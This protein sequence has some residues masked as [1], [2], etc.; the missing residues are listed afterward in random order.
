[1]NLYLYEEIM[2]L[3]LRDDKGTVA[4][5][6]V[7]QAVAGAVFAELLLMKKITI[8]EDKKKHVKV[9]NGANCGDPI[10]D[11][12]FAILKNKTKDISVQDLLPKFADIKELKH[13]VARQLCDRGILKAEQDKVLFI[14]TRKTYPELNPVP[15]Q[16]IIK[17][18]SV[19]IFEQP[20]EIDPRTLVLISLAQGTGLLEQNFDRK[21]LKEKKERIEQIV[22]GELAGN[23]T[24]EVIAAYEAAVFIAAIL[25]T[26]ITTTIITTS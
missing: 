18:M 25:P 1:M 3:A 9:I 10:I 17:R 12:C 24:R 20:K 8:S 2:L 19:A 21:A 14:F 13:K 11:E 7:E 4:T 5:S 15:E 16:N 22:S 26:I 6:Y 23:A